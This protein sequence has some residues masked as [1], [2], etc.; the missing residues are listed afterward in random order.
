[1]QKKKKGEV[2]DHVIICGSAASS[3]ISSP[4]YPFPV[5]GPLFDPF[6]RCY[7]QWHQSFCPTQDWRQLDTHPTSPS[8]AAGQCSGVDSMLNLM[9]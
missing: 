7:S 4:S 2:A 3:A 8:L 9:S 6:A 5:L 1:M